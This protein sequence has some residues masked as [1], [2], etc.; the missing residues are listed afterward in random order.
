[1]GSCC[2]P[3]NTVD[4]LKAKLLMPA[5][6]FQR[7]SLRGLMPHYS[8]Y[9]GSPGQA[10]LLEQ[11]PINEINNLSPLRMGPALNIDLSSIESQSDLSPLVFMASSTWFTTPQRVAVDLIAVRHVRPRRSGSHTNNIFI[12]TFDTLSA[13]AGENPHTM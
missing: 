11:V 13:A 3:P 10:S 12:H 6:E 5:P 8:V 2:V 4:P 9:L 1:M 7:L